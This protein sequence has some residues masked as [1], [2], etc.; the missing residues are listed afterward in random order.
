MEREDAEA[1]LKEYKSLVEKYQ[2]YI[3]ACGCCDSPWLL[4]VDEEYCSI[5][6]H[7]AFLAKPATGRDT[8]D[9]K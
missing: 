8:D 4:D 3:E 1:F 9:G 6:K 2:I 7:I 5:E